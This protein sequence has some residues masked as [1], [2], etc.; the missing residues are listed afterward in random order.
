[1]ALLRLKGADEPN[2]RRSVPGEINELVMIETAVE[3]LGARD[4]SVRPLPSPPHTAGGTGHTSRC[5]VLAGLRGAAT[6]RRLRPC[7]ARPGTRQR[8]T[9]P[10]VE[11]ANSNSGIWNWNYG[12]S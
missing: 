9:R 11:G 3:K 2:R 5:G 8:R 7:I 4:I 10:R 6:R 1:M 12:G